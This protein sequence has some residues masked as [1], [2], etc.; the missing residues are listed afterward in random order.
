VI[1]EPWGKKARLITRVMS[2]A[3]TEEEM[4]VCILASWEE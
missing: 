2:I 4:T 1:T 3:F